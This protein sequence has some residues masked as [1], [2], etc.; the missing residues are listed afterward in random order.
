MYE[1]ILVIAAGINSVGFSN[2]FE[3]PS[4]SDTQ[5]EE[6]SQCLRITTANF[7]IAQ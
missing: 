4:P 5:F 2:H 1:L 6:V 7:V 3:D